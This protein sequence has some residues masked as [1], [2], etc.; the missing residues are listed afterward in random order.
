MKRAAL[1]LAWSGLAASA[2]VHVASFAGVSLFER[3]VFLH[4]GLF[5]LAIPAAFSA[6]RRTVSWP[7]G[8]AF[9]AL[10]EGGPRWGG[11]A[12]AIGYAYVVANMV[13]LIVL[14]EGGTPAIRDGR[15]VLRDGGGLIR[16]LTGS[17]YRWQLAHASRMSSACWVLGYLF[18]IV[19]YWAPSASAARVADDARPRP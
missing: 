8:A 12:L 6:K 7:P 15:Y 2:V 17:E 9:R 4:L 11:R 14:S 5:L 1:V 10:T 19:R 18:F 16:E 13:T 3:F